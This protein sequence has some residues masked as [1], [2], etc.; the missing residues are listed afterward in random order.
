MFAANVGPWV[1]LAKELNLT[2]KYWLPTPL[3]N[4][5]SPFA[6]GLNPANL[7]PLLS[8]NTRLVAFTAVSNL[9]GHRTPV[10]DVV[11]LVKAKTGGRAIT[12]VDCVAYSPHGRMDMQEWGCDAVFF[13][14]YKVSPPTLMR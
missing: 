7:E 2:I 1:R 13:S 5:E 6:I 10:K 4:S 9:L 3:P 8:A 14:F 11:E 12:I